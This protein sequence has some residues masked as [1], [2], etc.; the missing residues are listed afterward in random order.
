[1]KLSKC[2]FHIYETEF[3]SYVVTLEGVKIDL[4]RVKVI[5]KWLELRTVRE[6][7]VFVGFI[8]YYRRFIRYFSRIALPLVKLT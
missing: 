5:Q 2:K 4:K 6:V 3:L 7:R 1:V 8:N